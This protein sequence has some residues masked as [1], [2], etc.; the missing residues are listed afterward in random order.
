M[1]INLV[2]GA[3]IYEATKNS[4]KCIDKND[5]DTNYFVVVPDRYSLQ[6]EKLLFDT[7]EIES[8]FNI[9]VISL[10]GLAQ[11]VLEKNG[12]EYENAS[13]L[14]GV[15]TV[16]RA[17]DILKDQLV[18]YKKI[19]PTFC[20]EMYK[21]IIQIKSSMI[22]PDQLIYEG[23]RK[24]V[25]D[26]FH[27][28]ALIYNKYQQLNAS[29]L[30]S[31][32]LIDKCAESIFV[33]KFLD[34]A[35]V[36]FAGF[37]SF[38]A[39]NYQLIVQSATSA[40]EVYIAMASST[41]FGN[42]Y[43]YEKDILEKIKKLAN[44]KNVEVSV[45]SNKTQF[46]GG[47]EMIARNLF[48]QSANVKKMPYL[49]VSTSS[50]ILEEV[51][52]MASLIKYRVYNGARYKDFSI[53]CPNLESY[54][55][56]IQQVFS[57]REIPYYIDSSVSLEQ[58]LIVRFI[59]KV[60][61]LKKKNFLNED[62]LY[63]ADS[64]LLNI[65]EREELITLLN[66]K[67]MYGK[68]A[69]NIYLKDGFKTLLDALKQVDGAKTMSQF[70]DAIKRIIYSVEENLLRYLQSLNNKNLLKE[71]A[72]E[73]QALQYIDKILIALD[74]DEAISFDDFISIFKIAVSLQEVSALPSYC[75]S[76]F[77]GD[78]TTSFYDQV[79]NLIVLG[80]CRGALPVMQ[81]DLGIITDSELKTASLENNI[82]PTIKMINRRN[83]FKL[84]N[85][86]LVAK[87]QLFISFLSKDTEGKPTD[88]AGFVGSL[89]TMFD[90]K[91]PLS[92]SDIDYFGLDE[93][94]ERFLFTL[95][96]S[97][98]S[99]RQK[100]L[101]YI[102]H[103]QAPTKF[104]GSLSASVGT[105]FEELSLE[106][107]NL[108]CK[109]HKETFF[110]NNHFSV[111]QM[112]RYF[113]CPFKH[114]VDYALKPK[115]K[116]KP[117]L[118]KFE[119]G[120][121]YH[122]V[123][124]NFVKRFKT[125]LKDVSD[126]EIN[127]FLKQN[128]EKSFDFERLQFAENKQIVIK[129]IFAQSFKVCKRAVKEAMFSLYKPLK[130]ELVIES[131]IEG[132][133]LKLKGKI[134]RVDICDSDI[135]LIDYKTGTISKN[136]YT[137]LYFG[138]KLQLFLY[139]KAMEKQNRIAGLYYF[140]ARPDYE[141]E[142]KFIL[143]GITLDGKIQNVDN[144]IEDKEFKKSDIINARR[145]KADIVYN[146]VDN[147]QFNI[148]KDYAVKLTQKGINEIK[149]GK[150]APNPAENSCKYCAYRGI[151]LKSQALGVRKLS[152]KTLDDFTKEVP[153]EF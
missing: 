91:E 47:Q 19:T 116:L 54:K 80:A 100:L 56:A 71:E 35:V 55:S 63:L 41:S 98:S 79:D 102:K 49:Q 104:V 124:E 141:N 146:K 147:D 3:N 111:S 115:I 135:R 113:D 117:Q 5:F 137:D 36:I 31:T 15:L 152:A 109:N 12:T 92:T 125:R 140:N 29:K 65:E 150:I 18:F 93:N 151:C 82:E 88:K 97:K 76:V 121:L 96:G 44:E 77:V 22:K 81:R 68:K 114:F 85:N 48:S 139:S 94:F 73:G 126:K 14:E 72:I 67:K 32:D 38:T 70:V 27:D 120:N 7:L 33:S 118:E 51:E 1:K 129:N 69:F 107:E 11:K 13:V 143:E 59:L 133:D 25:K 53:G 103:R 127:D 57:E 132:I 86:L 9:N 138:K 153:D 62:L 64:P 23:N 66:E 130:E 145:T 46:T 136:A 37:D 112:E 58:T 8:T 128:L 110:P 119:L 43:I 84:F 6:A 78:I 95:G 83:R 148:L 50:S 134:D 45:K 2:T 75:D 89:M 87:K 144:R 10:T 108:K 105:N 40:K 74:K 131:D 90:H 142:N 30:D 149:Q 60:F 26:K 39:S 4:F 52:Y 42:D 99:A 28:I 17:C 106:R 24:V 122:T 123:L 21:S 16:K 101:E 20:F 34:G 61:D